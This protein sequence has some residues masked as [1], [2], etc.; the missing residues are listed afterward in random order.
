MYLSE[1]NLGE[2]QHTQGKADEQRGAPGRGS[3]GGSGTRG[4]PRPAGAVGNGGKWAEGWGPGCSR[5]GD[6]LPP[7]SLPLGAPSLCPLLL[8]LFP[9]SV[10]LYWEKSPVFQALIL[11]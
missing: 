1:V 2:G 10:P 8:E 6:E 5:P 4:T 7:L 11:S 3:G 9:F